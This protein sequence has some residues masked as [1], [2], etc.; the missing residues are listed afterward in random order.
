MPTTKH[1]H[2][3]KLPNPAIFRAYDIR[4]VF[5]ATLFADDAFFIARAFASYVID[6]TGNPSPSIALGRDGR[7]STPALYENFVEGLLSCGVKIVDVGVGPTPMLYFSVKHLELDAGVMITGSHNPKDHNGFKMMLARETLFGAEIQ[8]LRQIMERGVFATGK[9]SL[10]KQSIEND[11]IQAL[12][13]CL[14]PG[15][16]ALKVAWD[17][18]NG[19]AGEIVAAMVK[20]MRNTNVVFNDAIDG[21]FPNHHPDPSEEENLEELV[22]VVREEQCDLGIAFDGDADRV[23]VVDEQGR[24]LWNDQLMVVLSR[25]V[26][27]RHEGATIIADVKASKMLFDEIKKAGGRPMVWKTGHSLIKAKMAEE[28]ALLAGEMSGHIFFADEYYGFDDGIYAALRLINYLS[29]KGESLSGIIDRLPKFHSTPE[30]RLECP[31]DRKFAIVESIK[32]SMK[33]QGAKISD[34]DGVR[35]DNED[36][37]WLIRASNTQAALSMRA[38]GK[39]KAS[40][41]RLKRQLSEELKKCGISYAA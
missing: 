12:L 13:A 35:V 32:G 21:N 15:G 11:Y 14:K 41:E 31:D 10:K 6:K 18:G 22:R 19:A 34:I 5:G 29:Q 2:E 25:D 28:G 3:N 16:K 37:W 33:K 23:G 17:P 38:E 20:R 36:G 27:E 7:L 1:H 4:G 39:D 30:I 26:L 40:L 8:K 9:G 24:I